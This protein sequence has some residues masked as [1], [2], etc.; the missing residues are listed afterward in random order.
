M[1]KIKLL[2]IAVIGLLLTNA[3]MLGF[4]LFQKPP[5]PTGAMPPEKREGPKKII[6]ERLQFDAAQVAQYEMLITG[7]RQ[8]IRLLKDS[9]SETKNELYQSLQTEG[10]TGKDS[11]T[12]LLSALQK[13]IETVHY[14]H[15][16]QIK[17]LC[18]PEQLEAFNELT[19][20]LAFYFT[21]ERKGPPPRH[22]D[23]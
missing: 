22:D 9:I 20:D 5:V 3:T 15:F 14:D 10:S 21:T 16:A 4:L 18:K 1:S 13:R 7:H 6:I 11:L 17:K 2:T 19:H 12:S 23:H 8:S